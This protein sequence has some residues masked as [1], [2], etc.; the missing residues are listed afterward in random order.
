MSIQISQ[1]YL[2]LIKSSLAFPAVNKLVLADDQIKEFCISR[3]MRDYFI[4]FPKKD[5]YAIPM[6]DQYEVDFPDDYTFGVLDAKIVDVGMIG[7]T[8]SGFWEIVFFQQVGGTTT[9][10]NSAGAYGVKGYNPNSALQQ[11]DFQRQATKSYQNQHQTVKFRVDQVNKKLIAYTSI[12]GTLNITWAKYS[13]NFDDIKYTRIND[14]VDLSQSY[15]LEHFANTVGLIEDTSLEASVNVDAIRDLAKEKKENV[16]E[17]WNE[18]P[19][20]TLLHF[21]G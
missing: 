20:V 12:Q 19:D 9:M 16:M 13:D 17:R 2:D 5:V 15:L 10:R 11:R 6:Q 3:A 8:G 1:N 21:F 7:G 4:K 14:V 18:T